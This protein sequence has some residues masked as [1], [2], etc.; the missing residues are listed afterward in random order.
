MAAN[1]PPRSGSNPVR[2]GA[3]LEALSTVDTIVFDKTGTLT[4]GAAAVVGLHTA[5][6]TDAPALLSLTASA[7]AYSEHPL[8]QAIVA[9]ARADVGIAMGSGTDIARDSADVVLISSDFNDL[10]RTTHVAKR[11]RRI[12]MFNFAGTIVVDAI[13]MILA[14]FGLLGPILA[15]LIH[16]GNETAFILNS[17]RLIPGRKRR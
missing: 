7:E 10:A 4:T 9:L 3:H 1:R 11:V 12:V 8:G 2:G 6:G 14:A 15:A 5:P 17:A 13:G 16:V